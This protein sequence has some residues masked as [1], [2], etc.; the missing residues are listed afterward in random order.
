M[1]SSRAAPLRPSTR[2]CQ[3]SSTVVPSGLIVP[4]AVTTTRRIPFSLTSSFTS[5]G[6]GSSTTDGL[7]NLTHE[8]DFNRFPGHSNRVAEGPSVGAP[9][10]NHSNAVDTKQRRSAELAPV[11]PP[12]DAAH[13]RANQDSA[14]LAGGAPRHLFA[15]RAED[16]FRRRLRHLAGQ[17]ILRLHVA[18]ELEA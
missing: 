5:N 18:D 12:A 9:V 10:G 6:H 17:H 7:A 16:E 3:N 8:V 11:E 13:A 15:Q 2:P 4:L 14:Q 1:P